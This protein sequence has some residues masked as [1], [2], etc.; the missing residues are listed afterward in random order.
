MIKLMNLT[1]SVGWDEF[2]NEKKNATLKRLKWKE[3]L[4]MEKIAYLIKY[5]RFKKWLDM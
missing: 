2:L 3:S 5:L 4:L 1:Y